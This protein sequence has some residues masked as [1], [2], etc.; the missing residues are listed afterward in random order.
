L[1]KILK[2]KLLNDVAE[3]PKRNHPTDAG[4]DL[5][6]ISQYTLMPNEMKT[7][8]TGIAISLDVGYVGLIFSRSGMGKVRV[9][10][11]NAVGVIDAD[12][13]GEIKVMVQ[14]EGSDP[15]QINPGDRIAQLVIVPVYTPDAVEYKGSDEDWVNTKRGIQG[16]GSSG[17]ASTDFASY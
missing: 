8:S 6:S 13:R 14:N 3:L 1:N 17:M 15:F 9:N 2:V 7:I 5:Q 16:F 11:S 10:L 4:L 12:Y